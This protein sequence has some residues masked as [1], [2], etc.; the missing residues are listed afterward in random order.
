[1]HNVKNAVV[2]LKLCKHDLRFT[3]NEYYYF[4][5]FSRTHRFVASR[6]RRSKSRLI[7]GR[8]V[9]HALLY[10]KREQKAWSLMRFTVDL[11][12]DYYGI[13]FFCVPAARPKRLGVPE[14]VPPYAH[15]PMPNIP[16]LS[17]PQQPVVSATLMP[18]LQTI[19]L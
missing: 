15:P 1:M 13:F 16:Q 14:T 10:I 11:V 7:K 8:C 5:P 19:C 3:T 4:P 17:L 12:F 18:H 9:M 6:L 2:V